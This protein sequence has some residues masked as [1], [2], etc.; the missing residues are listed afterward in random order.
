MV[1][2][3]GETDA[4]FNTLYDF[5]ATHAPDHV[6]VF[7]YSKEDG[8]PAAKLKGQVPAKIK[9]ERHEK[10]GKLHLANTLLRNQGYVG[11]TMQVVY[12]GID[13]NKELFYGRTELN[14]PDI[15]TLV[16]FKGETAELGQTYNV[17]ITGVDGYDLIGETD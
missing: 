3:P 5:I 9:K 4:D 15:D 8:T 1:G 12:E 7:S 16:Y 17:R 14:C 2:F 6:G 13:F 10:L 11:K